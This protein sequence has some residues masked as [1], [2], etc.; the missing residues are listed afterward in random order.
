M[1]KRK[2]RSISSTARPL[3]PRTLLIFGGLVIVLLVGALI[4]LNQ[5]GSGGAA[6]LATLNTRDVHSLAFQPGS[7][8]IIFFGHHNGLMKSSNGGKIWQAIAAVQQDAMS[9]ATQS[10]APDVIT[11][12]GHGV[13]S[14]S[15]DSG[16]TWRA[17]SSNLPGT[18]IHAFAAYPKN[19]Q[20]FYAYVVGFGLFKS[21]DGGARWDSLSASAPQS[22][23]GIAVQSDDKET[24]YLATMDAGLLRNTDDGRSW[25]P[26]GANTLGRA[27]MAVAITP[28][29]SILYAAS[30]RGLFKSADRGE[31]WL[32][33][34]LN[35]TGLVA[36]AVSDS[37]P[38]RV[39]VV[40]QRGQVYRSDD[41]GNTWNSQT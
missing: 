25:I 7:P 5:S 33:L 30:E 2:A 39:M 21:M 28:T 6:P 3:S 12:A 15:T 26:L 14:Q 38:Q 1:S 35:T 23:M 29:T 9:L 40:N 17:L 19:L 37:K 32:R 18:D 36:I 11:I 16:K 31:S 13:L 41:G 24:I 8:D 20:T 10:A 34:G 22:T 27:V 4:W